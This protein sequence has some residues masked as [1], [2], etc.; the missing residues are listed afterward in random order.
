MFCY[1]DRHYLQALTII[2]D[3]SLY[4]DIYAIFKAENAPLTSSIT[5]FQASVAYQPLGASVIAAGVAR[6]GNSLGLSASQ[7]TPT[8]VKSS[9]LVHFIVF[10]V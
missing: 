10:R 6:G 4:K 2:A 1:L 3:A 9:L 5:G 8:C 7:G